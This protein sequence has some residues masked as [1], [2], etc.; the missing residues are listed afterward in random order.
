MEKK[1]SFCH[2]D[3]INYKEGNFYLLT[4]KKEEGQPDLKNMNIIPANKKWLCNIHYPLFYKFKNLSWTQAIQ[5]V[6]DTHKMQNS[7]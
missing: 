4:F 3:P 6:S 2:R 5:R 1:C 7:L